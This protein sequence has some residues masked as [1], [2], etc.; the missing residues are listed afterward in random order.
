MNQVPS[1]PVARFLARLYSFRDD[2]DRASLAKLRRAVANPGIDFNVFAIIGRSLPTD[3]KPHQID[4]Y[5][6][7]ACLFALHDK[8]G[9]EGS[10]GTAAQLLHNSLENGQDSLDMRF[11]ALLNCSWEDLSHHLR[12]LVSHLKFHEIPINYSRLLADL[13]NWDRDD[14][15]VQRQWA[16][17]YWQSEVHEN[18]SDNTTQTINS[19]QEN[20]Q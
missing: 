13:L 12:H 2:E 9:G 5:L 18:N 11:A 8:E 19:L 15:R 10:I 16:S 6:L 20:E 3:L 1:T 4:V 14:R 7:V 17:N